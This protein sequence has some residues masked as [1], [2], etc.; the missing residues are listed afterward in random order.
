MEQDSIL[1]KTLGLFGLMVVL[2]IVTFAVV[3]WLVMRRG[4]S[5]KVAP[6]L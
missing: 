5:E 2:V 4:R 6:G 3:I 1:F